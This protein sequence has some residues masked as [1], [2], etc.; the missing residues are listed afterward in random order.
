FPV[1][2]TLQS[3]R[4]ILIHGHNPAQPDAWLICDWRHIDYGCN[5]PQ[6]KHPFEESEPRLLQES[7]H[8]S[9]KPLQQSYGHH[10]IELSGHREGQGPFLIPKEFLEW[11]CQSRQH[12]FYSQSHN[13]VPSSPHFLFFMILQ[14]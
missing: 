4:H 2:P 11:P 7:L 6:L 3:L 9:K 13:K 1:W 14:E 12:H 5:R 8:W 10:P